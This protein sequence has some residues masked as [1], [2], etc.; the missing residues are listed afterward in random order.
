MTDYLTLLNTYQPGDP[1]EEADKTLILDCCR[2]WG[3]EILTREA[4]AAHITSSAF[5]MSP[6][7]QWVLM[8]WHNIYQSWAWTGGHAD[9]ERDLLAVAIREAEEETGVRGLVPLREEPLSIEA[10]TVCQHQKQGKEVAAHLHLNVSFVLLAAREGQVLAAKPDENSGVAWLPAE[11]LDRWCNEA[12]MLPVYRRLI[13]RARK[14]RASA[15]RHTLPAASRLT[16][17]PGLGL[18]LESE[19]VKGDKE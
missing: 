14:T 16:V 12:E 3:E 17:V 8:V 13:Q 4:L 9:G 7:L 5:V 2:R 10:L 6:D 11:E 18:C 15:R 19:A 1:R